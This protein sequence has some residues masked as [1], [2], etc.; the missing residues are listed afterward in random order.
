M[1]A[2]TYASY[3]GSYSADEIAKIMGQNNEENTLTYGRSDEVSQ[4]NFAIY[5]LA[6]KPYLKNINNFKHFES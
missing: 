1:K 6:S 4:G 3:F 5:F 2:I